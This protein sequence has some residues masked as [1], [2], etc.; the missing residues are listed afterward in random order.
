MQWGSDI[1]YTCIQCKSCDECSGNITHDRL[2]LGNIHIV[3]LGVES[4]IHIYYDESIKG[5]VLSTSE[6]SSESNKP[7]KCGSHEGG[8]D[9]AAIYDF[10]ICLLPAEPRVK[11]GKR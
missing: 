6:V 11:D 7:L 1:V 2:S 5:R 8:Y 4:E 10:T 3:S 9:M